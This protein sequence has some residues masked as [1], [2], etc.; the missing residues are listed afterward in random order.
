MQKISI[1]DFGPLENVTTEVKD[2]LLFIGPQASGKSTIS[3]AIYFFR[4]LRDDLTGYT[5]ELIEQNNFEKPLGTFAK[6]IRAKFSDFWGPAYHFGNM[7]VSL[8][9]FSTF[10]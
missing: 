8:I 10:A 7:P 6:R 5:I 4:S 1:R 2:L 9:S 3:K